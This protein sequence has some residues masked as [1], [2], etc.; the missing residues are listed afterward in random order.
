MSEPEVDSQIRGERTSADL[1]SLLVELGRALRGLGF[2]SEGDPARSA[3]LDRAF[4]AFSGELERA[5]PL[6]LW[7]DEARFRATHVD[8]GVPH[9]HLADLAQALR[10]RDVER[11]AF[12]HGLTRDA[13][14]AF[15]E[16]LD[17]NEDGLQR[18]G[19]F[20]RALAAR[21]SA[22]IVINGG[23][24]DALASQQSLSATPA[25]A[26]ASLG[27]ALLA[28]SRQLVVAN[29]QGEAGEAGEE[30]KPSLDEHPLEAPASDERGERLVFRLIELDRCSDDTAYD[31]LAKRIVAWAIEL[32]D[33]G[34][35]D[36]CYRATLV[37][38]GHAVG[39]GGRSGLQARSA[40]SLCGE[41]MQ[42][43]RLDDLVDR[44]QS[45]E[46]STGIR[47]TQ[48]LLLLG[49]SAIPPLFDRLA[50]E[51]QDDT[52]AQ[53]TAI[54]ITLGETALSHLDQVIG[55]PST[56]RAQL[57]I[58]LAGEIQ[59][60]QLVGRLVATLEGDRASLRRDAARSLA[61]IGGDPAMH[62]LTNA[63]SCS[64]PEVQEVAA[65][66]LAA[67]GD[68]RAA[69]PLLAA[70]DRAL[71]AGEPKLA[72][73]LIRAL[74]QLGEERAV[75]KLVALMERRSFL[76]RAALR[77]L[78]LASLV[79]LD[80]LPGREA[81][82]AVERAAKSRDGQIRARADKLLAHSIAAARVRTAEDEK[83]EKQFAAERAPLPGT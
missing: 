59:S 45:G 2:Y 11:V 18:S 72:R 58:R 83:R 64:Q 36:E 38:A 50:T 8:S 56:E 33:E 67:L 37:L 42:G 9:G 77:D 73:E 26:A 65:H 41:L 34:L 4:M 47:A 55:Q 25:V 23:E 49:E 76:R 22:G 81:R 61:Q 71:R 80:K 75:P 43:A 32:F 48:V 66:C 52:A 62:A 19:G 60:P 28:R 40:Q 17:R 5:G 82:R 1:S 39:D 21:S 3:L 51:T 53:L 15:A 13:F 30:A 68:R 35:R 54:L 46:T 7:I 29:E 14:H 79:A 20:A 10:E 70:L 6:E 16:L 44:A 74:G 27:S 69:Q 12:S 31:F 63:V 78:Q 57:A 24:E